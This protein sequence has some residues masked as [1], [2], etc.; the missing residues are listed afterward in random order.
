MQL[1]YKIV[2]RLI[3]TH[4]QVISSKISRIWYDDSLLGKEPAS[5]FDPAYWQQQEAITGQANG[6]GTTYFI[7][8]L[9]LPMALRHYWRGGLLGRLIKDQYVFTGWEKTRCAEEIKLLQLLAEGGVR[10]PRPVAA[11]AVRCGLTYRADILTEQVANASDLVAV[12]QQRRLSEAEWRDIGQLI[13]KMH[14]LQVCHTD[15][16]IHNILLNDKGQF[17]LIDF[18]KCYQ[19]KGDKW[20]QSNLERL[21]RSLRKEVQRFS[22]LWNENEWNW[23]YSGYIGR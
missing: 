21:R 7:S 20:K 23:L 17:W 3:L 12:L 5:W 19:S 1:G 4:M 10:V 14:N 18:D 2:K 9:K 13:K 15:L 22:I 16:N 6:R 8:T 11:R